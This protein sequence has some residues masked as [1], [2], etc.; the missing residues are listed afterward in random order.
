MPRPSLIPAWIAL[1]CLLSLA[2]LPL[3]I[4]LPRL[5]VSTTTHDMIGP[6]SAEARFELKIRARFPQD[7]N[8]IVLFAGHDLFE[9]RFLDGL[10]EI[11]E[12][13]QTAL[14]GA[15]ILSLSN[16]E[17]VRGQGGEFVVEPLL[18]ASRRAGLSADQRRAKALAGT[19]AARS[20]VS[21]HGD[22]IALLIV[23]ESAGDSRQRAAL[24]EQLKWK[25]KTREL[26]SYLAGI[27]GSIALNIAATEAVW[28]EIRVLGPISL[29]LGFLLMLWMFRRPVTLLA[30]VATMSAALGT[31][32]CVTIA[33]GFPFTMV[34]AILIPLLMALS[35]ALLVHW[36]NALAS[37]ASAGRRGPER[38]DAAHADVHRPAL[39]TSL[40]TAAAFLSLSVSP[41]PVRLFGQSVAA[42]VIVQYLC[43]MWLVPALLAR[44]DGG[45]WPGGNRGLARIGR[46]IVRLSLLSMKH[47]GKVMVLLLLFLLIAL[48]FINR[49]HMD[50]N[51]L[52][53]LSPQHPVVLSTDNFNQGFHGY[54]SVEIILSGQAQGHFQQP[55]PLRQVQRLRDWA[56][57]Q[58]EVDLAMSLVNL[59]EDI[60]WAFNDE[61]PSFRQLPADEAMIA[62]YLL[63]YDGEELEKYVDRELRLARILL[64]TS[65][66]SSREMRSF[67]ERLNLVL[68]EIQVDG[69]SAEVTGEAYLLAINEQRILAG[70]LQG[71]IVASLTILLLLAILWRS[72]PA[73]LLCMLPNLF[74]VMLVLV[75]LGALDMPLNAITAMIMAIILGLSVDDTIHLYHGYQLRRRMG[76]GRA[77]SVVYS[78]RRAGRAV[79]ATTVILTAVMLVMT[80][81]RFG[82]TLEFGLLTATGI[83]A[84]WF[85]D[86]LAL[87]ALIALAARWRWFERTMQPSR[88]VTD[89]Q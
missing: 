74:P 50:A 44:W 56:N 46:P 14:P 86:M 31:A 89:S 41:D 71:L 77:W 6:D 88:R 22:M 10:D 33:R 61:D 82:P 69:V 34:T 4:A 68:A 17:Q 32:L 30:L 83:F 42:A 58:P 9:D 39:F 2:V 65:I 84:A 38:V 24:I 25:I 80:L 3:L 43:A 67:L 78:F 27:T 64:F 23:P 62:Q 5:A 21:K 15:Q 66:Y 54:T 45:E 75:M 51:V 53:F 28:S 81:S 19:G 85:F 57:A 40:T 18:D 70:Q 76:H 37:H 29:G 73:A 63:I 49:I 12:A 87:P 52:G 7:A 8:L 11:I 1:A 20:F 55:E 59:L 35:V 16:L 72:L 36:F 79:T 47:I 48:P 60:H 26:D 13:L